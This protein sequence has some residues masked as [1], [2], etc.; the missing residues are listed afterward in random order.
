[1][2]KIGYTLFALIFLISGLLA[3]LP[4][5]KVLADTY[6]LTIE[7]AAGGTVTSPGEGD[8]TYPP[9][10]VVT[11]MAQPDAGYSFAGWVGEIDTI[12][13]PA[14]A[15]TTITMN[16]DYDISASFTGTTL[17]ITASAGANGTIYPM[18]DSYVSYG[19]S[20]TFTITPDAG[21]RIADVVV[22]GL[23]VGAVSTYT[24]TNVTATHTITASF[25]INT[26]TITA[27]AG[28][29]GA[30]TPPGSISVNYGTG[31]SF[32]ITP[33]T[34]YH[35]TDVVVDGASVGAVSNYTF[36]NVTAAHTIT[37]NFAI[38]TYTIQ[39]SSGANGAVSPSGTATVNYGTSQVYTIT[40][41]TGYHITNVL[42]D[43]ASAGAVTSYTFANIVTNHTITA[44]FAINT[45]TLTA[46]QGDHGTVSP[47]GPTTVN[48]GGGQ[49]FTI[50]PA[51]GYH[52]SNVV[53][54]DSFVGAVSSYQFSNVTMNHTITA[55]FAINTYTLTPTAG[56]HGS[57][58]PFVAVTV[59][60]GD[61]QA[62]TIIPDTAYRIADVSVDG[63]SLGA[64]STY[65][66]MNVTDNHT[67]DVTFA[68]GWPFYMAFALGAV[69]IFLLGFWIGKKTG[70]GGF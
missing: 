63:K 47:S 37:A 24:F 21:Y 25:A 54:D 5:G 8:F 17:I 42:V 59:N 4:P 9:G 52:I 12:A 20:L 68:I 31:Q 40:P 49:T 45:Y 62:F 44:S 55:S 1:M 56:N 35:I 26:F 50:T 43:G 57:I 29:N 16:G 65:T 28:A 69:F 51:T 70:S 46:T 41:V 33:N 39:A 30:I 64:V 58:T 19:G 11:L 6:T 27:T 23:S 66:F 18:G 15:T 14:A 32:T 61:S 7:S 60:Y 67:I 48:Y 10:S 36:S 53:V 34:G 38:N 2:K 22:D 3:V 13:D